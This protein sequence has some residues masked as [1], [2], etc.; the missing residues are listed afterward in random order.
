M[1]TVS[2]LYRILVRMTLVL[3]NRSYT[4]VSYLPPQIELKYLSEKK[5][6]T[7]VKLI[8]LWMTCEMVPTH[9]H[10]ER[11]RERAAAYSRRMRLGGCQF[12][13]RSTE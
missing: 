10:Y 6:E 5:I 1:C 2:V 8:Q 12:G 7:S 3:Y 9:L 11:K 4:K 13:S